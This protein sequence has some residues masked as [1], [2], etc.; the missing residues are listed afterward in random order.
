MLLYVIQMV[1]VDDFH[2]VKSIKKG[3]IVFPIGMGGYAINDNNKNIKE[4]LEIIKGLDFPLDQ[5]WKYDPHFMIRHENK[6]KIPN[7]QAHES[8]PR[9]KSWQTK[10]LTKRWRK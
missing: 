5:P 6:R 2:F 7:P 4:A 8:M 1:E 3:N 10:N 9:L